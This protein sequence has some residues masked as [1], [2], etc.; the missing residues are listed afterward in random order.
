MFRY[1]ATFPFSNELSHDYV[2]LT[3]PELNPVPV[4]LRRLW[5]SAVGLFLS[6][7]SE[8]P[9]EKNVI[10]FQFY[11]ACQF[12]AFGFYNEEKIAW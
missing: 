2:G 6:R 12:Q 8:I 9:H 11:I 1:E 4:G 10:V 5:L 7:R 3:G